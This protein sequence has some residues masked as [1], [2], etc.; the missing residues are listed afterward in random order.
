M[1]LGW[2]RNPHGACGWA[3]ERVLFHTIRKPGHIVPNNHHFDTTRANIEMEKAEAQGLVIAE[4][5][6][7]SLVNPFK[8][9]M[10][11]TAR[12]RL[13][14]EQVDRVPLVMITVTN[15]SGGG[16][17]GYDLG[18]GCGYFNTAN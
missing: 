7:A 14:T 18:Y 8:G 4:G 2:T 15:N 1:H 6:I 5:R 12:E 17:A 13:W 11:L 3:A 16:R 10:D 9:N